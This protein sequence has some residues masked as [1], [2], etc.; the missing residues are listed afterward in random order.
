MQPFY[1]ILLVIIS[2]SKSDNIKLCNKDFL[3]E[4]E[5]RFYKHEKMWVKIAYIKT[6][7]TKEAHFGYILEGKRNDSLLMH[8]KISVAADTITRTEYYLHNIAPFDSTISKF[9]CSGKGFKNYSRTEYSKGKIT[10][11]HKF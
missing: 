1:I 9:V 8:G 2:V 3:V 4:N 11:D 10:L 7:G 6:P 5:R